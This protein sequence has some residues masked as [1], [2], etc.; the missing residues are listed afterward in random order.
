MLGHPGRVALCLFGFV[1]EFTVESMYGFFV[2]FGCVK[3]NELP[4]V[5]LDIMCSGAVLRV[6]LGAIYRCQHNGKFVCFVFFGDSCL[7]DRVPR[8]FAIDDPETAENDFFGCEPDG[9]HPFEC[10]K[11]R[12]C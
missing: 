5:L 10:I 12:A 8:D 2:I 7:N 6:I 4:S 3:Q 1:F 11:Y 9:V